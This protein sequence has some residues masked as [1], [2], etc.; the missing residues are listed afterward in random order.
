M[1]KPSRLNLNELKVDS[2][3]TSLETN[4]TNTVMG[5][6]SQGCGLAVTVA[7]VVVVG[8]IAY[9]AASK[10]IDEATKKQKEKLDAIEE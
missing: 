7:V 5:G 4:K 1:K 8:V 2:F 3:I 9:N 6:S 10:A